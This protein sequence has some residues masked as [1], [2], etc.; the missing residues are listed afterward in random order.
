MV[1]SYVILA[2]REIAYAQTLEVSPVTP[3]KLLKSCRSIS[4]KENAQTSESF[5]SHGKE[6]AEVLHR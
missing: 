4:R 1:S 6:T 2:D 3:K 5:P